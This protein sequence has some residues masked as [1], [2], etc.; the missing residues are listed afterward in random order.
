MLIA[1]QANQMIRKVDHTTSTISTIAGVGHCADAVN[2]LP[3]RPERRGPRD[4]APDFIFR[5]VR[6]RRPGAHRPRPRG[7]HLRRRHE[8]FRVRRSIRPAFVHTFA[9]GSF[10]FEG[11][12]GP[13]TEAQLA[14]SAT[15]PSDPTAPVYIADTD[16]NCVRVVSP[17]GDHRDLRGPCGQSGFSG[18]GGPATAALL[19]AARTV[20]VTSAGDVYVADT[21]NQRIR[22]I[23][24]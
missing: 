21:H 2:P 9:G 17:A 5:S 15:S 19:D 16:N 1:D 24:H 6:R 4:P 3:C 14:V 23:Y 8:H 18:D 20:E 11:D 10:G 13:A 12:G 22:V 7:E